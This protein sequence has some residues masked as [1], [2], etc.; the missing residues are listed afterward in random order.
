MK[1]KLYFL[2][3]LIGILFYSCENVVDESRD[4]SSSSAAN[5]LMVT[6]IDTI[7]D[8]NIDVIKSIAESYTRNTQTKSSAIRKIKEIIPVKDS[9]GTE[10]IYIVNYENN[11]GYVLLSGNNEYKPVLAYNETGNFNLKE[12]EHTGV[13]IWLQ[14]QECAIQ[15]V[16]LLP[17]SIRLQNRRA[18]NKYLEKKVPVQLV[19][20]GHTRN[21][22][23]DLQYQVGVYIEETLNK[24]SDEGYTI[25]PYGDG[26]ILEELFPSNDVP[27]IKEYL[28][29][30]AEDRFFDGFTSTVYIRVKDGTTQSESVAPLLKTTWGQTGGYA[31]S[32]LFNFPVGCAAVAIGQIMRYHE[33]PSGYDWNSMAYTYPT[34]VTAEFL[35]DVGKKAKIVYASDGS[36]TSINNACEA[37]KKY[38]YVNSRVVDHK[39]L[40]YITDQ[41]KNHWPVYIRGEKKGGKGHAWVCDGFSKTFYINPYEV[42]AIDK[43][44]FDKEGYPYYRCMHSQTVTTGWIIYHMNWGWEGSH[45]G[46]YEDTYFLPEAIRYTEKQK[47]IINI[48]P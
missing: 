14:T 12:A 21:V 32:I 18:W 40:I 46:Y 3:A 37:L 20:K 45:D 34:D 6:V 38:G 36:G 30:N 43:T 7:D 35:S 22:D 1:S 33:Y 9:Q 10:I 42:M 28:A 47:D 23:P 25:Y 15:N 29:M 31:A 8:I 16:K 5:P 48:H 17:D 41:L 39:S 13:S 4:V 2:I 44:V 11:M 26:T 27:A 19:S 24:W